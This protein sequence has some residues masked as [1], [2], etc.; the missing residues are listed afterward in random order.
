MNYFSAIFIFP[1]NTK[2]RYVKLHSLWDERDENYNAI[3]KSTYKGNIWNLFEV[4]Y[5]VNG[6][7]NVWRYDSRGNRLTEVETYS[8]TSISKKEYEYYENSDLIKKAGNW[9][10][11]YD[12]NGNLLSR[13]NVVQYSNTDTFCS[14]DFAQ[15][16]GE[17]WVYEYDLQNRLIKTSYSGKGKTNLKERASYTYDYRGLLVRKSYQDYDKSN[18]IELDKPTSSKEITEYYEYTPD[19]RVLYNER[20]DNTI[21]NK[22]DYIWANTTLWC[23]INEGVLYYHHTD[24]LG[25]TEAITDSNGNIV[26]HADYEAFGNVMNERGEE[27]FTPNY[28]GKFFDE[29]SGLYY[30]NAR[31]YD[32][33]LGRFTTQ[34]PAR[35]GVNWYG[36]CGGNPVNFTD[37]T[38]MWIDN[39]DGTFTAQEK[40]SLWGLQQ[41]TGINWEEFDYQGNPESLQIG[42]TVNIV[43]SQEQNN[44]PTVDST[45]SAV[46]H[47]YCG[48]G[49]SVNLG[50]NTISAL[51]NSPEHTYNQ[52]ALREGTA[53][54]K[55]QRYGVDLTKGNDTYHVGDTVVTYDK[56]EGL[57]Y[58]VVT[59]HAFNSDGFWD[60]Y[61]NKGDGTGPK[62]ELPGGT[63]YSYI[64]YTW[65]E[66]YKK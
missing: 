24:H 33:E 29:S 37:S 50:E 27:N 12:N 25:T 14:W 8:T 53:K 42:Q 2:A 51:K 56:S 57:K 15:K 1:D 38:G 3:N 54:S 28:T 17:L 36:Y 61:S 60:I 26:W 31:W 48:D 64:P 9:Y 66:V 59:Y 58:R 44:H 62:K 5:I 23:E 21:V 40:D 10:F 16:E 52:K 45:L 49:E 32:C 19:G 7:E 55:D 39:G 22:T 35:D 13:G 65:T 47:Y 41:E 34:D 20:K 46:R 4:N 43:K 11:N 30:F 6:K 18:Y 63:P